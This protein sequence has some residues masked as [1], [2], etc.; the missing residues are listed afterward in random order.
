MEN[1]DKGFTRLLM[2][3]CA[4][5]SVL[6][7]PVQ[8]EGNGVIVLQRDVQ[9]RAIGRQPFAKDPYPTTVNANPSDRVV[10]ATNHELSDGDFAGI[11]SGYRV[12]NQNVVPNPNS[13]AGINVLTN[14]NGLPGMSAGHG[15]GSGNAISGTITRTINIGLSP[16]TNMGK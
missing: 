2:F 10:Q 6:S 1:Y 7:L 16:L 13:G 4:L 11:N 9:P 8:A 15:G 12:I 14:P 5:S 3:G